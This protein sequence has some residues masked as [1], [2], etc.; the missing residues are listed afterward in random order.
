MS[1][2]NLDKG[3]LRSELE[4]RAVGHT[5]VPWMAHRGAP[6]KVGSMEVVG[7]LAS[8]QK[9]QDAAFAVLA[10][11]SHAAM[12]VALEEVLDMFEARRDIL[13]LVGPKEGMIIARLVAA[14]ALARGEK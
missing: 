1:L 10:S 7:P 4:A 8:F 12:L 11:N 9:S 2:S 6:G 3:R 14:R 13:A 5:P